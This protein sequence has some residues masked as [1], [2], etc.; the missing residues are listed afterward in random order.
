MLRS[1]SSTADVACLSLITARTRSASSSSSRRRSQ[2]ASARRTD[3][4]SLVPKPLSSSLALRAR[5]AVVPSWVQEVVCG[6]HVA[7]PRSSMLGRV[8]GRR[9]VEGG[10]CWRGR[11]GGLVRC[12]VPGAHRRLREVVTSSSFVSGF[13]FPA[14]GARDGAG[15]P[16]FQGACHLFCGLV[17]SFGDPGRQACR[18]KGL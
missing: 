12:L 6:C 18:G 14:G 16:G 3:C 15:A 4:P 11:R 17:K 9:R 5:Q 2:L 13:Y 7:S 10:V 8:P 1:S